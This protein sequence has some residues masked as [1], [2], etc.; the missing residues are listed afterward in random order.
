MQAKK[1]AKGKHARLCVCVLT[2]EKLAD[3]V[4]IKKHNAHNGLIRIARKQ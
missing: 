1:I 4:R 3:G 2:R